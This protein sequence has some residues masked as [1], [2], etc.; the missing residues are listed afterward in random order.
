MKIF[1]TCSSSTVYPPTTDHCLLLSDFHY[2]GLFHFQ[3]NC[4]LLPQLPLKTILLIT[5]FSKPKDSGTFSS[6]CLLLHHNPSSSYIHHFETRGI[7][8][9]L[10][11]FYLPAAVFVHILVNTGLRILLN[12]FNIIKFFLSQISLLFYYCTM[13]QHHQSN[14]TRLLNSV[15]RRAYDNTTL[16][17]YQSLCATSSFPVSFFN[18][19]Y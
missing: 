12:S 15:D 1:Q 17:L 4:T 16:S 19:F 14:I 7:Y 11:A 5:V 3:T 13:F 18:D 8:F 6:P 10:T 2:S 9:S